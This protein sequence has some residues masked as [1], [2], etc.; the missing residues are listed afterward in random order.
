MVLVMLTGML[1][2]PSAFGV[3]VSDFKLLSD[4]TVTVMVTSDVITTGSEYLYTYQITDIGDL[5]ISLLS[6]PFL[7]PLSDTEVSNFVYE[8][9]PEP[10][11]WG[12]IDDSDSA[13][14]YF[15]PVPLTD[16]STLILKFTSA[17]YAQEV[18][19]FAVAAGLNG[20]TLHGNLLA[21]VPEPAT[22]SILTVGAGIL[23]RNRW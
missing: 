18:P 10:L 1:C 3:V 16:D 15:A 21:P 4:E 11:F 2:A 13:Q 19:G 14:A 8:G 7:T 23:F 22:L 9:D 17:Y 12:V 6:I 20:V 5:N